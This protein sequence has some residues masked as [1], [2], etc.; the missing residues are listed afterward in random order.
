MFRMMSV[1]YMSTLPRKRGL[2]ILSRTDVHK[3]T[4]DGVPVESVA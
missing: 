4:L 1:Q 3:D 2:V